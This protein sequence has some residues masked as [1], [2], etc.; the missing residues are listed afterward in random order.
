MLISGINESTVDP[1]FPAVEPVKSEYFCVVDATSCVVFAAE[2]IVDSAPAVLPMPI[3]FI[4]G[5]S[6]SAALPAQ[7]AIDPTVPAT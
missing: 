3:A 2:P 4:T 7:P 6:D 5:A 1:P